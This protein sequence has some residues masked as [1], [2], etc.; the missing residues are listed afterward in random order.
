MTNPPRVHLVH[1][2]VR[3]VAEADFLVRDAVK[4]IPMGP[5]SQEETRTGNI[6]RFRPCVPPSFRLDR[7]LR[8]CLTWPW[9]NPMS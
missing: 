4:G 9:W 5:D 8:A 6:G 1:Y 2:A 3:S 7:Y